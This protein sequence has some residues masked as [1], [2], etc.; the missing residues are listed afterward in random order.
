MAIIKTLKGYTVL[1]G[2]MQR[3]LESGARLDAVAY[4]ERYGKEPD[5]LLAMDYVNLYPWEQKDWGG[6][7]DELRRKCGNDRAWNGKSAVFY[8]QF[9][10]S[11][12]PADKIGLDGLRELATAWVKMN[13]GPDGKIGRA[14]V[15]IAYHD[16]N[17]NHIPHAHV[18]VNNTDLDTHKRLHFDPKQ[19]KEL[20][21]SLQE[22]CIERGLHHLDFQADDN[23]APG[24]V[25]KPA[26]EPRIE[27][28]VRAK[29]KRGT[30]KTGDFKRIVP[31]EEQWYAQQGIKTWKQQ[32]AEAVE[33][34]ARN[35]SG[36]DEFFAAL[37]EQGV[38]HGFR[39]DGEVLYIL[40]PADDV[41]TDQ[42]VLGK[43][44]GEDY[45]LT[46]IRERQLANLPDMTQ[47]AKFRADWDRDLSAFKDRE[48]G[49]RAAGLG[50]GNSRRQLGNTIWKSSQDVYRT[51]S[52]RKALKSGKMGWKEELRRWAQL[53]AN[54]STTRDEWVA[55]MNSF[56]V[57]TEFKNG[58]VMYH[59]P[60][61]PDSR[62]CY[63]RKLGARFTPEGIMGM[64]KVN[65]TALKSFELYPGLTARLVS[66]KSYTV[67][68]GIDVTLQ[69]AADTFS[70]IEK[71]GAQSAEDLRDELARARG[72]LSLMGK[73]DM[74]KY[75]KQAEYVGQL[76][77]AVEAAPKL[78]LFDYT[79]PPAEQAER[80]RARALANLQPALQQKIR[81]GVKSLPKDQYKLLTEDQLRIWKH[82][83]K[84]KR[85]QQAA[86]GSQ[87]SSGGSQASG[88]GSKSRSGTRR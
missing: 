12:D 88:Q 46:G 87:S 19:Y 52:E 13:F 8:N 11:P 15:A 36:V 34:A 65:Q 59:H 4:F 37:D 7:M 38:G 60:S 5:R 45:T 85:N 51:D 48:R 80:R 50:R 14:Q 71:S 22:L 69:Q 73:D 83:R 10:I 29:R 18:V 62:R 35:S 20:R 68:G 40:Q 76:E 70:A 67:P 72:R 41:E 56:G 28:E 61:A 79:L 17:A 43:T 42:M 84:V 9:V 57:A 25:S 58:D 75:N 33:A 2:R 16:D 74:L 6:T 47:R 49:M 44:L 82:Y 77:S 81:A 86:G 32:I 63:G 24:W 30:L 78:G 3:Y 64:Q 23:G 53:A 21:T 31:R 27:D 66:V 55:R 26:S 54:T 1:R 39:K